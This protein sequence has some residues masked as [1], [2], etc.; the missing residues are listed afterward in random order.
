MKMNYILSEIRLLWYSKI[1]GVV[2]TVLFLASAATIFFNYDSTIELNN[3]FDKIVS[4]YEKNNMDIQG[5]LNSNSYGISENNGLSKIDNPLAYYYHKLRSAIFSVGPSYSSSLLCESSIVLLPIIFGILGLVIGTIDHKNRTMKYKVARIGKNNYI[6]SKISSLMIINII[7]LIVYFICGKIFSIIAYSNLKNII[8][9]TKVSS[10][11]DTLNTSIFIQIVFV[12][13]IAVIYS[14]IGILLG[15]LL[16][17]SLFGSIAIILYC[18]IVPLF[19]KFDLKNSIYYI[20]GKVY[21][22]DG[23]ISIANIKDT[24]TAISFCIVGIIL[25]LTIGI[26]II[27]VKRRSAFES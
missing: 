14:M 24:S 10:F 15:E 2:I 23:A 3:N 21:N 12:F 7:A 20:A 9:F 4:Y 25:A 16:K 27:L 26:Y 1:I 13:F 22:F 5:D 6:L 19:S 8:D 11:S 18:I 17:S